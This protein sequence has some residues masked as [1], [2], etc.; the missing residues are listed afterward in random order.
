MDGE[1]QRSEHGFDAASAV[2]IVVGA[3]PRA[4]ME[5]RALAYGLRERIEDWVS[6]AAEESEGA[7]ITALVCTDVWVLND[8]SLRG[9]AM[10]SVGPPELNAMTAFL[11]DKLAGA[12]VVEDVLMVQVDPAFE[13]LRAALWGVDA[14]TT[15]AAVETFVQKYLDGFLRA[16]MEQREEGDRD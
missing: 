15:G 10:I 16:V 3:H 13:D 2:L 7:G 14:G 6:K 4:E 11:A 1:G 5:H 9:S 12:F 8:G